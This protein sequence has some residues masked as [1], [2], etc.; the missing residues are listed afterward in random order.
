[1]TLPTIKE[2]RK[3]G[4][5][6]KQQPDAPAQLPA[7]PYLDANGNPLPS[8]LALI[9]A[10]A[11]AAA[12]QRKIA[13]ALG[14]TFKTFKALLNRAD[15]VVRLAWEAGKAEVEQRIV[16]NL[17]NASD[18]GNVVASIFYAK[19]NLQW[20]E[21]APPDN[22]PNVIIQIPDSLSPENYLRVINQP[23]TRKVNRR[24]LEQLPA[25]ERAEGDQ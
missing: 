9:T 15:D 5:P 13:A 17:L 16:Q 18:A 21:Q 14:I 8:G 2:K 25:P 7:P 22:R 4:R 19:T 3:P 6:R 1:M 24:D 10:L 23:V 20:Q 11:T 12:P